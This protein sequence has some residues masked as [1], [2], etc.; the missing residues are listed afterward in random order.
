MASANVNKIINMFFSVFFIFLGLAMIAFSLTINGLVGTVIEN[1]SIAIAEGEDIGS[2]I[3]PIMGILANGYYM[4]VDKWVARLISLF[5]VI[6]TYISIY[7]LVNNKNNISITSVFS[8]K[9]WSVFCP[10]FSYIPGKNK[11]K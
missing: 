1:T 11:P 2:I 10:S 3:E 6:I 9:Y 8:K 7:G 5:G 4:N